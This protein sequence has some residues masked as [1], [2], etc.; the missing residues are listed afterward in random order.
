MNPKKISA[1]GLIHPSDIHEQRLRS[2]LRAKIKFVLISSTAVKEQIKR[3]ARAVARDARKDKA[4]NLQFIIVLKGATTF[5]AL[6]AQEIFKCG[7]PP[8]QLN[9][10]RAYSY[11]K[12]TTSS[13]NVK[14]EGYLPRIKGQNVMIVEDIVDTG[15]TLWRLKA[16]LLKE[17]GAKSV[18]I[19]ALF[20]KPSRRLLVLQKRL[21]VDYIGFHI[22]DMFVVGMGLDFAEQFRE[23]PFVAVIHT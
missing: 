4:Q 10:I 20:N 16:H 8:I 11:G 21:H 13:G 23:L 2:D 6:L 18:K 3:M 22:P 19:C 7:G 12:N 17:R 1:K 15:L 14:L 5:G 9:F